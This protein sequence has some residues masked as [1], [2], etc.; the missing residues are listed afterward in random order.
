MEAAL[1]STSEADRGQKN[2]EAASDSAQTDA[3]SNSLK[4]TNP[5][6]SSQGRKSTTNI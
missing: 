4:R 3:N 5:S 1:A 2:Q 6:D